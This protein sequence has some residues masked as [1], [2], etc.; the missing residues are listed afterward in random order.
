MPTSQGKRSDITSYSQDKKLETKQEA[1]ERVNIS[2]DHASQYERMA[3]NPDIV[4]EALAEA[5][6]VMN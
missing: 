1:I 5:R 4:E 3:A 6:E 2:L